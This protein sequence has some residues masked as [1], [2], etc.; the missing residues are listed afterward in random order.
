MNDAARLCPACGVRT[1]AR[2]CPADQVAT[3]DLQARDPDGAKLQVGELVAGKYRVGQ[4]LGRGGF[5]AVYQA[6]H[7]GGLGHVALKVLALAEQ[8]EDEIRRFYREAQ[9]TAKLRHPNTVRVFDV[10]QTER[11][12]LYI[13]MELVHGQSLEERLRDGWRRG[14]VLSHAEVIAIGADVLRSLSEAHGAGLV[15]RDLKPANL[16]LGE[17]DGER[18]VKVLDFG[19]A[20]VQDSSLTGEGRAL[21]TPAYM[22]PEQCTAQPVDARSDL[23]SLGVILFRCVCGSTPFVDANP[24]A[25][26]FAHTAAPPPDV[27]A[28]ARTDLSDEFAAVVAR[29]LAKRPSD[30]FAS[31]RDMRQALEAC[32]QAPVIA[33]QLRQNAAPGGEDTADRTANALALVPTKP[34][35]VSAGTGTGPTGAAMDPTRP[36]V[37]SAGPGTGPTGA[38]LPPA[39]PAAEEPMAA[40]VQ[41]EPV[42]VAPVASG[43]RARLWAG[44]AALA[45]VAVAGAL[46]VQA[47]RPDEPVP[48]V[49]SAPPTV[50]PATPAAVPAAVPSSQGVPTVA[51]AQVAVEAASPATGT[52]GSPPDPLPVVPAAAAPVPRPSASAAQAPNGAK[53]APRRAPLRGRPTLEK[54]ASGI[55]ATLPPD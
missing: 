46:A 39:A 36:Y 25:V 27:L 55:E 43:R 9:V 2:F 31:A 1:A 53:P 52:S 12:A 32:A 37:V 6:E 15:H 3:F 16:M 40:P 33:R 47:T 38:G 18:M 7:S 20:H 23:Y 22:S 21:G 50:Q 17:V 29:A 44:L 54:P 4:V 34:F 26:M 48:Q 45:A 42:A 30:R 19:I 10:G 35:V 13:A 28:M 8:G 11:G 49:Q 24:L 5:G 41:S 51:P 14:Q